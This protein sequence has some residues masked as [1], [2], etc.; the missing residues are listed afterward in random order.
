M[1]W[2]SGISCVSHSRMTTQCSQPLPYRWENS[3]CEVDSSQ[4]MCDNRW[5][6]NQAKKFTSFQNLTL[7]KNVSQIPKTACKGNQINKISN[8][9]L[10]ST[11]QYGRCSRKQGTSFICLI[12]TMSWWGMG[13]IRSLQCQAMELREGEYWSQTAGRPWRWRWM[14]APQEFVLNPCPVL[15][16]TEPR[17]SDQHVTQRG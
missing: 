10:L 16:T 6:Q 11:K 12:P 13:A 7:S 14:K 15:L 8:H 4:L 3:R 17:F 2:V 1:V 9:Y 5:L